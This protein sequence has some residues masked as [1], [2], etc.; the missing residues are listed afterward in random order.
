[1]IPT[2]KLIAELH[3]LVIAHAGRTKKKAPVFDP[4]LQNPPLQQKKKLPKTMM[5]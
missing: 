2:I 1:M 4:E 3:R 5:C